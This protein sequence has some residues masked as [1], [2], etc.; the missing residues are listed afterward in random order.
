MPALRGSP[1]GIAQAGRSGTLTKPAGVV[2]GDLVLI[3]MSG[4]SV[5]GAPDGPQAP[6]GFN[7]IGV[8]TSTGGNNISTGWYWRI[9][10]SEPSSYSVALINNAGDNFINATVIAYSD[11]DQV[12]PFAIAGLS[13]HGRDTT[14]G[15]SD[16]LGSTLRDNCWHLLVYG[17][18]DVPSGT[19]AGYTQD[20]LAAEACYHKLIT[21]PGPTGAQ[22]ITQSVGTGWVSWTAVIQPPQAVIPSAVT[23]WDTH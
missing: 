17:C 4:F 10:S 16:D 1:N 20:S 6:A 9:A 12:T 5:T 14:P 8:D 11:V 21:P 13:N 22:S 15:P 2:D 19:P 23:S 18:Y 3:C 7:T